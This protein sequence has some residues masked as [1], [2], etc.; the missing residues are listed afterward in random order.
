M[1]RVVAGPLAHVPRARAAEVMQRA[2][3]CAV[4]LQVEQHGLELLRRKADCRRE[5]HEGE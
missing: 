1:E 4:V 2:P 3:V 5:R